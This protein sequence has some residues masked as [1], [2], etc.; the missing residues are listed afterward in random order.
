MNHNLDIAAALG[1]QLWRTDSFVPQYR[2]GEI[3]PWKIKAGGQL[4]NDWGYFSGPCLLESLP[5]L[6]RKAVS[7]NDIDGNVWETWMSLTPHEIESQELR[8]RHAFGDMVIMGLG[9]GWIAANGALNP[10]VT[11]VTVVERDPDVIRLFYESGAFESIPAS[12]RRKIEIVN[13]DAL[14]WRPAADR[15]VN[16]LYADIWLHLAEPEALG[17]VRRMQDNVRAERIY[18]WGQELAIHSAISRISEG[19]ESITEDLIQGA[20]TD[21]IDLPLLI[22]GD[23]DYARMIEQVIENRIARRRSF[24]VD[25]G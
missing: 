15:I 25:I 10:E 19:G 7:G 8:F 23:R 4:I 18:Y 1:R 21:V 3:G 11:R 5:S 17:Q 24:E 9:M 16:F 12:A 6:A 22:P 20:V 13:A 2:C 14:E